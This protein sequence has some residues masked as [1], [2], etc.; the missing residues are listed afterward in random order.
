MTILFVFILLITLV[1]ALYC[2]VYTMDITGKTEPIEKFRYKYGD[3]TFIVYRRTVLY[4]LIIKNDKELT[5]FHH[6]AVH[7]WSPYLMINYIAWL[8]ILP[9]AE[10]MD[11]SKKFE[12][13]KL[14]IF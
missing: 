8:N 10:L 1:A 2:A 12:E 9:T 3:Y 4:E 11:I 6:T 13:A 14:G 7:V 5:T